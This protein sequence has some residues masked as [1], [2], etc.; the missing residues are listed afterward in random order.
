MFFYKLPEG[1][2]MSL[3]R[4]YGVLLQEYYVTKRSL[5]VIIDIFYFAIINFFLFG[6]ISVYLIGELNSAKANYLI[7]GMILWE[8]IRVSQYSVTV[9]SLWNLW[10]RNLSNMFI[11]SLTVSEYLL[12]QMI[13]GVLKTLIVVIVISI[14]SFLLFNF[15]ILQLGL[16]NLF[17]FFINLTIFSW[18]IGIVLLGVIFYFGVRF[19]AFAWSMIYI[20]QMLGAAFFPVKVLPGFIQQVAYLIPI[21]HTF[22]AARASLTNPQVDWQAAATSFA[23][24]IIYFILAAFFFNL[25]FRKSK[26]TGQFA[27][28]EG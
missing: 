19:Q 6:Y 15:N 2:R 18:S 21:T 23:L 16:L 14:A 24:N 17:L 11:T 28:N 13:S 12:A 10:S 27:R 22:E 9:G 1:I 8:V 7:I 25:M 20:F 26:E 4:I 5:E 3:N